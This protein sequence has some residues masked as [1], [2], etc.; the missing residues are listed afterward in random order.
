MS[1]AR[2][3]SQSFLD[4]DQGGLGQFFFILLYILHVIHTV[5][6]IKELGHIKPHSVRKVRKNSPVTPCKVKKSGGGFVLTWPSRK[7]WLSWG[8][9]GRR[10]RTCPKKSSQ[11]GRPLDPRGKEITIHGVSVLARRKPTLRPRLPAVSV[12]RSVE[13]RS[14]CTSSQEPPRS[15]RTEQS[16]LCHALLSLGTP[17]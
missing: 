14:P 7:C 15:T 5:C 13:R 12:P 9:I 8:S 10:F 3:S 11:G 2:R 6:T 1:H 4:L 17:T 16:P